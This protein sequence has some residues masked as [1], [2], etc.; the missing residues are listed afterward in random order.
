[1]EYQSD[2]CR[3]LDLSLDITKLSGLGIKTPS[4]EESL[5]MMRESNLGSLE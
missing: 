5:V 1:M 3:A 4:L 2:I